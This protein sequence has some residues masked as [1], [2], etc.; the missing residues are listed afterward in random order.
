MT[1]LLS[2]LGEKLAQFLIFV[3]G[4]MQ[5]SI[6]VM[7]F[8]QDGG[9]IECSHSL[10][11]PENGLVHATGGVL[12]I[13]RANGEDEPVVVVCGGEFA[14]GGS[15]S[16]IQNQMCLILNEH[17]PAAATV[18]G[19]QS[20]QSQLSAGGFLNNLRIGAASLVI[21]RGQTLWVTAGSTSDGPIA[22]SE[23]VSAADNSTLNKQTQFMTNS[24]GPDLPREQ[25]MHHCLEMLG[26]E[27]AMLIG[28]K[29]SEGGICFCFT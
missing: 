20:Q 11:P 28:G 7:K 19:H 8:E 24:V 2:F 14:L 3:D 5:S 27:I 29:H 21:D 22:N 26:P 1:I 12:A 16:D 9:I 23:F 18:I 10:L 13:T 6:S 17:G 15:R 4:W 25:L